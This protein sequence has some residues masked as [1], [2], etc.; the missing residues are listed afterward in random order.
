MHFWRD[1]SWDPD[2]C[3]VITLINKSLCILFMR[4][5]SCQLM[6]PVTVAVMQKAARLNCSVLV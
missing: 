1:V 5:F 4:Q 6:P 3:N 2:S